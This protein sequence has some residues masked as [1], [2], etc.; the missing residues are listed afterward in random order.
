MS[1]CAQLLQLRAQFN[2]Q[3]DALVMTIHNLG[4]FAQP[5][6]AALEQAR[7]SGNASFNQV[8]AVSNCTAAG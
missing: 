4:P 7:A 6:L 1:W 5:F 8:L 3:V 2:A